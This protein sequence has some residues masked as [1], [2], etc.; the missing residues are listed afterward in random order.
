M[1][2]RQHYAA[3]TDRQL[4]ELIAEYYAQWAC[5]E[6]NVAEAEFHLELSR[7]LLELA[8]RRALVARLNP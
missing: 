5:A 6:S 3:L 7:L 8:K 4:D 2:R 1:P